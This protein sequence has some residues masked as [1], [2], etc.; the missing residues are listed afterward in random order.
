MCA[1]I[2]F[3]K[4]L[5][6]SNASFLP[7]LR[8]SNCII[9]HNCLPPQMVA[10]ESIRRPADCRSTSHRTRDTFRILHGRL[11]VSNLGYPQKRIIPLQHCQ[12]TKTQN[13]TPVRLCQ[14]VYV[15]VN[16]S[17][18]ERKEDVSMVYF[19]G[20]LMNNQEDS[21]FIFFCDIDT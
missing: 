9:F 7:R 16:H 3:V 6:I 5:F 1:M 21:S 20:H 14:Q 17:K 19:V 13:D 12:C 18:V 10:R 4:N 2:S 8:G 15:W 11:C